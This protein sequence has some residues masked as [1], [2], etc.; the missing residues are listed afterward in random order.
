MAEGTGRGEMLSI[1]FFVGG[2]MLIYGV[3][4]TP[5]DSPQQSSPDLLVGPSDDDLWRLLHH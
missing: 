2:L 4:L 3:V 1:W 5:Y